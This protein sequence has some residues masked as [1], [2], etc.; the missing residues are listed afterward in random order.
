VVFALDPVLDAEQHVSRMGAIDYSDPNEA[1]L[2]EELWKRVQY[3]KELGPA[4]AHNLRTAHEHDCRRFKARRSGLYTPKINHF[5]VGDYVFILEQGQ[6]PGGTLG[7]RARNKVLR[8]K[9]VKDSGVLILTNQAGV[10]FE[11][12]MSHC[13][14]CGLPNLLGDTYTGL[15]KPPE[16]LPC[17]VCKDH[18]HWDLMLLCNNCDTGWHTFCLSPPLES[19]PEG[20]W[21]CPDCTNNGVDLEQLAAKD[22][23]Y[24]QDE[25]SRPALELPARSRIA[26]ARELADKWHGMAVKHI[27]KG[28]TRY[29][30]VSFQGILQPNWFRIDWT[31]G[32]VTKHMAHI[33]SRLERL[34]ETDLPAGFPPR[35]DPVTIAAAARA[36]EGAPTVSSPYPW[37]L[38]PIMTVPLDSSDWAILIAFVDLRR[39]SCVGLLSLVNARRAAAAALREPLQHLLRK[40]LPDVVF[41]INSEMAAFAVAVE[42]L[43]HCSAQIV[44][45][46]ASRKQ[47][48]C[49]AET[50]LWFSDC[51]CTQSYLLV[52]PSDT[53]QA[54]WLLLF[55][56]H[57]RRRSLKVDLPEH[58]TQ[59]QFDTVTNRIVEIQT[60]R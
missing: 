34:E 2:S 7:I 22:A 31:N 33:F 29:G 10:Q 32:S 11:K 55:P 20:K 28:K 19:I 38:T 46:K 4:I 43:L 36:P 53:T 45:I 3:V 8:V 37:Q 54:S 25:R 56:P 60:S 39:F 59:V 35:P 9:T 16:D 52:N 13:V 15:V 18:R 47:V 49:W 42:E 44:M 17:Q 51:F 6:K 48:T 12:H 58:A 40:E 14:P 27:S 24:V 41:V 21:I 23:R 26:K 30:R 1:K 57:M 5:I 50:M